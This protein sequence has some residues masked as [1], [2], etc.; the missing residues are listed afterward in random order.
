[1][2]LGLVEEAR[3]YAKGISSTSDTEWKKVKVGSRTVNVEHN[4]VSL[5][6][7]QPTYA[8]STLISNAR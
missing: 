6:E 8:D 1:M 4:T 5:H 3:R 7:N 2:S